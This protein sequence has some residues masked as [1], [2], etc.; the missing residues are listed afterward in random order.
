MGD[1]LRTL[2]P[3]EIDRAARFQFAEHRQQYIYCRGLLRVI[4]SRYLHVEP[5]QI[6]F[7]Y[8]TTGKPSLAD[9]REAGDLHFNLSHSGGLALFAVT[10][11]RE[12][13][14]DLEKIRPTIDVQAIARRFFSDREFQAL[15]A[16]PKAEQPRAFFACWTRKE[17]YIKAIG[18]G[19][20]FPLDHFSVSVS[21]NVPAALLEV[22]GEPGPPSRWSL[23]DLCPGDAYMGA[24]AFEGTPCA[25]QC[26]S[27]PRAGLTLA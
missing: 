9:V 12:I 20:A 18:D 19:L 26:W 7:R 6:Q 17:A 16:L 22:R 23:Q 3:D 8:A 14:V 24:V 25:V 10:G 1:L 2:A 4:L 21:P 27:W 13:G 5:G 15:V 11:G